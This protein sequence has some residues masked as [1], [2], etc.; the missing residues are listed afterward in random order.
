MITPAG[1]DHAQIASVNG[2]LDYFDAIYDHHFEEPAGPAERNRAINRLFR[3]HEKELLTYF[4]DFLRTRDD[5]EILGSDHPDDRAP[6]VSI[7]PKVKNIEK[8]YSKLIEHKLML[9]LGDFYAVRPLMD[10]EIPTDPGVIRMSF[11]H[12][13]SKKDI[14]QLIEGLKKALGS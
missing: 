8:V 9:G 4:L 2:I 10:M 13:T 14:D 5:I 1:P 6:I 3:E 11:I 7:R 12:Y